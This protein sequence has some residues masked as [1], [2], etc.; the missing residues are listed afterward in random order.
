L[1]DGAQES[2]KNQGILPNAMAFCFLI[3][4]L[5]L[6]KRQKRKEKEKGEKRKE[7]KREIL[8]S[9]HFKT[10]FVIPLVLLGQTL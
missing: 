8:C 6:E 5:H 9:M 4:T 1:R 2:R 3:G 7:E 10:I